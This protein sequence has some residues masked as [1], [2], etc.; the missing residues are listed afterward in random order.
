MADDILV[1]KDVLTGDALAI[2]RS[3]RE[4]NRAGKSTKL[5]DVKRAL[6]QD[7]S[8]DFDD[9]FL[10]LRK[11]G[12]I[13]LD[14]GALSLTGDGEEVASGRAERL[15]AAVVEHFAGRIEDDEV[16]LDDEDA[17]PDEPTTPRGV[18]PPPPP[19]LQT[20][21]KEEPAPAAAPE[22]TPIPRA[23]LSATPGPRMSITAPIASGGALGGAG[24][25]RDGAKGLP[26][27]GEGPAPAG[28]RGTEIDLRYVKYDA[29]GSGAL[30]TV[31]RG[32]HTGLGV[33]VAIKELRDIFGY[34]SFL[35][36]G[37]VIKRL[38]KELSAQ[39]QL[40]HPCVVAI[41]DQNVDVA[42]PYFIM[43]L[44]GGG[45]LRQKLEASGGKGLP[46]DV[47]LRFF[48]QLCYGL[49]AAHGAGLVHQ[50]LKP[51]NVLVD[52]RGNAKLA[53]FGLT[54][55]IETD[56]AKGMPQV[57][58]G[59]GAMGYLPPELLSKTSAAGPESDVY[60]LGII[61]YE[62]LTG[63]LPG[64]RS[65]LPSTVNRDVPQRLDPIFDR[66]TTDRREERYPTIGA[67]LDDF[68][69]AFPDRRFLKRGD[70]ILAAA[71]HDPSKGAEAEKDEKGED[72][73]DEG[74]GKEGR[75]KG[76]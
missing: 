4:S 71:A 51:E 7:I 54:R 32:K 50:G 61:L 53:D 47:A 66:M 28:P 41:L 13:S 60:S 30:G 2:L 73:K 1:S 57:F 37:E 62:T 18:A 15:D 36:R 35:Q 39:A 45:S 69:A 55:V 75:K 25:S 49:E 59:T 9:Y 56:P 23:P 27:G 68:Y 29:I 16:E 76:K 26:T 14:A 65:P 17:A 52:D 33:E 72:K 48:L 74:G 19:P 42:R 43:E 24:P 21:P 22:R 64:R 5:P 12:F 44:C 63:T 34:F 58:L 40:R 10:F 46:V 70:L 3:V 20:A 31:F 6:E 67:V 11:C 38:K 8:L